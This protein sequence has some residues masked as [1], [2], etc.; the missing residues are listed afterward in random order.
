MRW[1]VDYYNT[2]FC[3]EAIRENRTIVEVAGKTFVTDMVKNAVPV[4]NI[5][6]TL[7]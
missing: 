5:R 7:T 2:L 4:V 6:P 1:F 3:M